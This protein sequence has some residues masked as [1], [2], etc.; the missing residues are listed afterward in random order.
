MLV[1]I[2]CFYLG[3][4][5]MNWI[6]REA[7]SEDIEAI[8][9]LRLKLLTEVGDVNEANKDDVYL[10]NLHYFQKVVRSGAL[11]VWLAET[12]DHDIIAISSLLLF[13]RPPHG[14][15][16]SGFEGYIMNMYTKPE[17]RGKG[18][19]RQLINECLVFCKQK[20]V[21]CVK[22]HASAD[23]YYL[24]KSL[25]FKSKQNEMEFSFYHDLQ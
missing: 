23:G 7:A 4:E 21:G 19:A 15:N 25:G 22:L 24:Y 16:I 17:F 13:E 10:A 18:V 5:T 9:Q 1:I 12:T 2:R 6:I 11:K 20:Q 14:E 8:V 3:S